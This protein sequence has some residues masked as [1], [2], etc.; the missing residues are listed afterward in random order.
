M[1][2]M[3]EMDKSIIKVENVAKFFT[4]DRRLVELFINPF[5]GRR[6]IC[7]LN[8]ISFNVEPGEIL[9]VVGP[10]GAGKTTLLRILADLL[11]PDSGT[12]TLCGHR[13]G[14]TGPQIRRRIGYVSS[15]ERS[16]FW[17][18]TGRRN[19]KFF[20]RL[21][22]VSR[23]VAHWRIENLLGL[24]GLKK[25]ADQLFGGYSAGTRKKFALI[26]ALVH[27]P[28]VLLL[29]EV[30]N[31]LDPASALMVK[32][33]IRSYISRNSRRVALWST[34]RLEEVTQVCDKVLVIDK[35]RASFFGS[36]DEIKNDVKAEGDCFYSNQSHPRPMCYQ[37]TD[38]LSKNFE[39]AG[40]ETIAGCTN[41]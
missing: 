1:K 37:H 8:G 29:D 6:K 30:T 23:P 19:L 22:G 2:A 17:R 15:D 13:L 20:S 26:R 11:E 27:K 9:G 31:S 39:K 41:G 7:A 21:Y 34:H 18:L 38:I 3:T 28:T 12:V 24:F 4:L 16:F 10:N 33:L 5:S 35:G 32:S 36:V 25:Q 14:R 40:V